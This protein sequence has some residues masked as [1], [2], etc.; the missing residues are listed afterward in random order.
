MSA[1]GARASRIAGTVGGRAV[2]GLGY[3]EL[4]G[5]A[6]RA[7]VKTWRRASPVRVYDGPAGNQP[8]RTVA[9]PH[10]S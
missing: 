6:R 8:S 3:V 9:P 10:C 4:T 7:G 5:Y 2:R 1:V